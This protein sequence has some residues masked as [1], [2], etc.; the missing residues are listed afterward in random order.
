M[1][2]EGPP[3]EVGRHEK[4]MVRYLR[5]WWRKAE[6][7]PA[8]ENFA[9]ASQQRGGHE[10]VGAQAVENGVVNAHTESPRRDAVHKMKH[11]PRRGGRVVNLNR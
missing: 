9:D 1:V 8:E 2:E 11:R 6:G 7:K 5:H 3:V 4:E 10:H